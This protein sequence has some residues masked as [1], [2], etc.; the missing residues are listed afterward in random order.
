MRSFRQLS[1]IAL[2]TGAAAVLGLSAPVQA[3]KK[4]KLTP[5]PLVVTLQP[6]DSASTPM[7]T[8][9]DGAGDYAHGVDG[10]SAVI[11]EFGGITIDFQPTAASTRR[12][13]FDYSTPVAGTGPSG[14]PV[15][16]PPGTPTYSG[17]RTHLT[18][19][20]T[21]LQTMAVSTTQCIALG[22]AF[23]YTDGRSYRNSY[24]ADN[25]AAI[26]TTATAFGQVTRLNGD[27]WLLESREGT[28]NPVETGRAHR[29]KL[30]KGTTVRGRTTYTDEGAF[31]MGFS[32]LLV[33]QP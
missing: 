2:A 11:N 13:Q 16:P 25:I 23:T 10:V 20:N 29:A 30:V 21:P 28:C 9:S 32:M 31:V 14:T 27:T 7:Q 26:D 6:T 15:A 4:P 1:A 17:L 3:Q 5:V 8:T 22:T 24:Q 33:R 18:S 19:A 12:V